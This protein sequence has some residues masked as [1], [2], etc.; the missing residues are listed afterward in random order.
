M[1][2]R[3]LMD[4][5]Y[6]PPTLKQ[7]QGVIVGDL[8]S[9]IFQRLSSL[10]RPTVSW[11]TIHLLALAYVAVIGPLHYRFRRRLDYRLSILAFL[12]TVLLFG[13]LFAVV[14]RRGYGESQT[15]NSLTIARALGDGRF[16][17]MQWISAFATTG[18]KYTLSHD[19]PANLYG[20]GGLD[21]GGTARIMN[22]KDG[23]I[24]LDIPLY[25][26]RTFVH[27][28]VMKGNDIAVTVEKTKGNDTDFKN[29]R[30]RIGPGFPKDF[31]EASLLINH[32]FY[33]LTLRNGVLEVS[34]NSTEWTRYFSRESL[35]PILNYNQFM[36]KT[37]PDA[38]RDLMPLLAARALGGSDVFSQTVVEAAA[39]SPAWRLCVVAPAPESFGLRGAGF[40]HER[41]WVYYVQDIAQP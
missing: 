6:P 34:G 15:V 30:L 28:A 22:G 18:A 31:S 37:D 20:T 21:D 16:D 12:A 10:T 9:L 32:T 39:A 14:G 13:T 36:R 26:S 7:N 33:D 25:S 2:E 5:R 38:H 4:H 24:Q 3:Y 17:T 8:Q 19:A 40:N 41:G 11:S 23:G 35:Q 1:S 29:V 27:R